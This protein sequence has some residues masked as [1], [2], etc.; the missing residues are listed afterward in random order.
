M[1]L[2][3]QQGGLFPRTEKIELEQPKVFDEYLSVLLDF[4]S[5][6]S[7]GLLTDALL[8]IAMSHFFSKSSCL[9]WLVTNQTLWLVLAMVM[10]AIFAIQLAIVIFRKP[11]YLPVIIYRAFLVALGIFLGGIF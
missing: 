9:L 3:N 4:L 2:E 11:D 6:P 10:I 7:S 1:R 8:W 5:P